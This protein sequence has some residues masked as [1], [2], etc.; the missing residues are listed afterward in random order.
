[1][2]AL[3]FVFRLGELVLLIH[4]LLFAKKF[5]EASEEAE[6]LKERSKDG[7]AFVQ[8]DHQC[9]IRETRISLLMWG[10]SFAAL[11]VSRR[12]PVKS[13]RDNVVGLAGLTTSIL[14]MLWAD[15]QLFPIPW[16]ET[17]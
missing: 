4:A 13:R 6:D 14:G 5:G 12:Y 16:E 11:L 10:V 7:Q 9:A 15:D 3:K 2:K 8:A 17:D 1:M